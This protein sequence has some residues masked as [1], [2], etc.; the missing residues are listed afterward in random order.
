MPTR[1]TAGFSWG[2]RV[3]RRVPCRIVL[4]GSTGQGTRNQCRPEQCSGSMHVYITAERVGLSA[5]NVQCI[6]L[7]LADVPCMVGRR[8]LPF[9]VFTSPCDRSVYTRIRTGV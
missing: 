3:Q 7:T 4:I 2:S 5:G 6:S 8:N 1:E 9:P